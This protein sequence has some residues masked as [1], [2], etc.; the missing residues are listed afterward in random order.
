MPRRGR[1]SHSEGI[2][3]PAP[4]GRRRRAAGLQ[5]GAAA[6]RVGK[7][8]RQR[9][10]AQGDHPGD[11]S[12][13]RRR[14]GGAVLHRDRSAPGLPLHRPPCP[15][16]PRSRRRSIRAARWSAATGCSRSSRSGSRAPVPASASWCSSPVRPASAR[17]RC[18]TRFWRRA[19]SDPDLL[20]AR[21][22]CLEHYGAAEAY[23]PVLEAF[24]RLL[25][26]PGAERVIRVLRD[27]RPHMA[28]AA[29]VAGT[30]GRSRVV[31]RPGARGHQGAD[32]ARDG[33]SPRGPVRRRPPFCWCSRISTGATIRRS[34]CWRCSGG[35]RSRRAFSWSEAIARW[36]SSW[37]DIRCG[38]SSRSCGCGAS[39]RTSP[40]RSCASRTSPR[41]WRNVSA[42]MRFRPSWRA[43]CTSGRT[44]IRSSWCGWWTSSS[45]FACWSRRTTAGG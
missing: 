14:S 15:V 40:S 42:G 20:I 22:A 33:G 18:S 27:P 4:A 7:D 32:V 17:P 30:P 1:R 25:R 23:L 6:S 10:C 26:E 12:R 28:G 31:A 3:G 34:I 16:R 38:R 37:R 45:P 13:A 39:A 11:P 9:R 19:A 24:G 43:P 36:T 21:G 41:I 2:C 35:A 8:P 29:A 5:G 44:A